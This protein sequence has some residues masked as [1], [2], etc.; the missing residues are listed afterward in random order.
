M[1][2]VEGE[3]VLG[4]LQRVGKVEYLVVVVGAE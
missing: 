4:C 1:Q 2:W 3:E